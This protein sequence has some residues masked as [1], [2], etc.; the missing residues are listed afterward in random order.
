[1][2]EILAFPPALRAG[3]VRRQAEFILGVSEIVGERHLARQISIQR[4]YLQ[5]VGIAPDKAER[6]A[7]RLEATIRA[8]LWRMV[9]TPEGAA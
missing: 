3:Y 8:E 4:G 1:M 2:A 6:E 7:S 9:L 5:S